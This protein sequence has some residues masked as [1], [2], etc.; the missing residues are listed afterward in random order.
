MNT[1]PHLE[2]IVGTMFSGKS[3]ELIRRIKRY[4]VTGLDFQVFKPSID[5]RYSLEQVTSHDGL[6]L[7]AYHVGSVR[8]IRNKTDE[9]AKVIG[10]E[11]VQFFDSSIIDLCR[12]YVD[13]GRIVVVNGLNK[14][15]RDEYFPFNDGKADMSSLLLLADNITTL[16]SLCTEKIAGKLCG[17]E[18]SRT[19]KFIDGQVAPVDSNI[20]QVGGKESYSPRCRQHFH[21][22]K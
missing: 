12:D 10:V 13:E 9:N 5:I 22:Y 17:E 11:E 3:T 21:F 15:F 8:E 7:D 16:Y 18:A 14:D 1:S 6:R 4:G 19:Q 2:V 20:V